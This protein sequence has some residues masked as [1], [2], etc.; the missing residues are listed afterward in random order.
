MITP[1][2]SLA[3]SVFMKSRKRYSNRCIPSRKLALIRMPFLA[4]NPLAK[5]SSLVA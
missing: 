3:A 2:G 1:F 5:K 4:R